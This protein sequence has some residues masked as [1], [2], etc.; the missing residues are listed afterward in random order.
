MGSIAFLLWTTLL[1]D[2]WPEFFKIWEHHPLD[3]QGT[4][5]GCLLLLMTAGFIACKYGA[6]VHWR[7]L[8]EGRNR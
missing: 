4:L 7:A 3:K 2:A 6:F 8:I 5:L 1:K